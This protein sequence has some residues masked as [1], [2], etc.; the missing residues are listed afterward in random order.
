MPLERLPEHRRARSS[1]TGS[2]NG[3]RSRIAQAHAKPEHGG[4]Q[5]YKVT[6][7]RTEKNS[8]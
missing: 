5:R 6:H 2:T 8:R 1:R 7:G 4:L 3:G